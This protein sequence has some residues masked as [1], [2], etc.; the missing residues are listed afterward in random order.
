M[1]IKIVKFS[2]GRLHR[3]TANAPL[4]SQ[5]RIRN[6]LDQ[7]VFLLFLVVVVVGRMCAAAQQRLFTGDTTNMLLVIIKYFKFANSE[8]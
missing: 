8:V 5:L 1:T 4:T 3:A 7:N 6:K 2:F